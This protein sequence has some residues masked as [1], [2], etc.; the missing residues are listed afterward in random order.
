[1]ACTRQA[2]TVSHPSQGGT[3]SASFEPNTRP[4]RPATHGDHAPFIDDDTR[5]G[6]LDCNGDR[7]QRVGDPRR[8]G[9]TAHGAAGH[10]VRSRQ[11]AAP[12]LSRR[13]LVQTPWALQ[14]DV[15]A[16]ARESGSQTGESDDPR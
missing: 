12:I 4:D 1:V 3:R 10:A 5:P 6:F 2:Q 8:D 16:L 7:N 13:R 15:D 14:L 11:R 9:V